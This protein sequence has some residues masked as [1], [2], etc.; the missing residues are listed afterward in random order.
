M[1]IKAIITLFIVFYK[2]Y[3]DKLLLKMRYCPILACLLVFNVR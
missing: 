3:I 2:S 1:Y